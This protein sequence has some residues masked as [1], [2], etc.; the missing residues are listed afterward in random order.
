V[1]CLLNP[2]FVL[3]L[4][5]AHHLLTFIQQQSF[6]F[7][8]WGTGKKVR[9]APHDSTTHLSLQTIWILFDG[10]L[11]LAFLVLVICLGIYE[12]YSQTDNREEQFIGGKNALDNCGNS[13]CPVVAWDG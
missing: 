2:P 7:E 10:C 1:G 13:F 8:A 9:R 12:T 5:F 4:D 3:L 6:G 11:E